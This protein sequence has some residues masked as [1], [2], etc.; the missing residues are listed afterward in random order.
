MT[1]YVVYDVFT[2]TPFG[3][4][5]LAVITDARGLDGAQMQKIAREFNFSE[6]TFVLPP[7]DPAHTARVRIFT[8]SQ[9]IPF[10]GHPTV[11]TA[12]ALRDLGRIDDHATLELG[13]G[14]IPVTVKDGAAEFAT[15]VPL[16]TWHDPPAEVVAA[17]IS[18]APGVVSHAN[19]GPVIA[20]VGLPFAI[21]EL[22][23]RAALA[24]AAINIDAFRAFEPNW[25][26]DYHFD[27]L[28]YVRDGQR[29]DARMFAPL[30]GIPEDPATGSAAAALTAFFGWLDGRSQHF[31]VSQ[32]VDMG[33]PSLIRTSVEVENGTPVETRVAGNAVRVMEGRL[34]L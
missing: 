29:I 31:E 8:P 14:P 18:A 16:Q 10:A 9:E 28:V 32:G 12:I 15:R 19:H 4:N 21:A 11:G 24:A 34:T 33:R 25:P 1:H 6:S 3:G 5:P 2:D 27:L 26:T 17:A 7:E 13:V 30:D 20:S 22:T 23:D